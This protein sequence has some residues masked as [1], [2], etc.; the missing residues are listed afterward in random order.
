MIEASAT[1]IEMELSISVV[2]LKNPLSK[3]ALYSYRR[4]TNGSTLAG[5]QQAIRALIRFAKTK[6]ETLLRR[7]FF[8][9]D[10]RYDFDWL[11]Q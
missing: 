3:T 9:N 1:S 4:A 6:N 7:P 10:W 5:N 8:N 11:Q 2:G